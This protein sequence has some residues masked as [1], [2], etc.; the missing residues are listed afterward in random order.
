MRSF[1]FLDISRRS[2]ESLGGFRP[3]R[4]FLLSSINNNIRV[5]RLTPLGLWDIGHA[6]SLSLNVRKARVVSEEVG[7]RAGCS[8]VNTFG[9][10]NMG[11]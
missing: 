11:G 1:F 6:K 3:P 4:N 10:V 2:A 9:L 7:H 8:S 5:D